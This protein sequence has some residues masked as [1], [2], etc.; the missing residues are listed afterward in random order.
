MN[1]TD[2]LT[3]KHMFPVTLPDQH[4]LAIIKALYVEPTVK[5]TVPADHA[6]RN[7]FNFFPLTDQQSHFIKER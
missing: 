1:F 5:R 7:V 6:T 3:K 2:V 4:I